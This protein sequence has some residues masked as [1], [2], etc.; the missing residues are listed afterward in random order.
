MTRPFEFRVSGTVPSNSS[1]VYPMADWLV[2]A[3]D[4]IRFELAKRWP[5]IP[6]RVEDVTPTNV[7]PC[8]K[9]N[10][11]DPVFDPK[12]PVT[13]NGF[14]YIPAP[15]SQQGVPPAAETSAMVPPAYT[16]SGLVVDPKRSAS[17]YVA[18]PRPGF[19]EDGNGGCSSSARREGDEMVCVAR[20]CGL[21]W[22]AD[23]ERPPC[24]VANRK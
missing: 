20:G 19:Y 14:R 17:R 13:V 15:R 22:G 12:R 6:W 11:G 16:P 18:P 8:I 4:H 2:L 24:P 7:E 10:T 23:E 5:L 1:P 21:R 9:L 3:A